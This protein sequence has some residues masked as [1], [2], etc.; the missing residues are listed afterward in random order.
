LIE[1]LFIILEDKT[2]FSCASVVLEVLLGSNRKMVQLSGIANLH[3]LIVSLRDSSFSSFCRILSVVIADID[4]SEDRNTL[5]AQDKEEKARVFERSIA[6]SNQALLLSFPEFLSRMAKLA[7][8]SLSLAPTPLQSSRRSLESMFLNGAPS[9]V[10]SF[11]DE[12]STLSSE[13]D[14]DDM[15]ITDS[16]ASVIP[17]RLRYIH[18]VMYK[19]EI[20]YVLTLFLNGKSKKEVQS[21]LGDLKLIPAL[22]D[23]FDRLGWNSSRESFPSHNHSEA[24]DCDCTP[25]S[26]LKIQFL[27]FVHSFC[28]HSDKKHLLLSTRE[29]EEILKICDRRNLEIPSGLDR[30]KRFR[31]RGEKG[32]LTKILDILKK[33]APNN[34]LRFW[35]SRAIEGFL[36]GKVSPADQYFLIDRNIIEHLLGHILNPETKSREILQSSFDLLGELMKF[37]EFAFHKFN[38]F[39]TSDVQF[40][41]FVSTMTSNVV[42]SNMFI[43]CIV[44]SLE[45][46]STS[47][48]FNIKSCR[49]SDLIRRWEHKMYLMYKL[50]TSI[51]VNNLTQENVSCLNT[52][53]IFLMFAHSHH[54]LGLYLQAFLSEEEAQHHPG[55]ILINL[56]DLLEFW[57][58]HYLQRTKDRIQLEQS[59]CIGF[60][61]WEFL[62]DTLLCTDTSKNTSIVHYLS[63]QQQISRIPIERML[64]DV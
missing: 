53:L 12:L 39:V 61:R 63:P 47:K 22:C 54:Q 7:G 23:L 8:K 33:T 27:R 4:F 36:R 57:R 14:T 48:F 51:S 38:G 30:S 62:V 32:L 21:R 60:E 25:E 43:R 13:E 2:T 44:L 34:A 64:R 5:L 49:L 46:F 10:V 52:T 42:D 55:L 45:Q 17:R 41:K 50:I 24:E 56:R 31:C 29:A 37:N 28:D 9:S 59:S 15:L 18:E 40:E 6:D 11:L 1:Y 35:L 3:R 16:L 58:V 20:F 19:V 26:A